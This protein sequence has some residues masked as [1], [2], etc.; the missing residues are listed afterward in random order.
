[1][2]TRAAGRPEES[3]VAKR[4]LFNLSGRISRKAEPERALPDSGAERIRGHQNTE[5]RTAGG[6]ADGPRLKKIVPH[7]RTT[8]ANNLHDQ[9]KSGGYRFARYGSRHVLYYDRPHAVEQPHRYT[10]THMYVDWHDRIC[11]RI[12]WPRYH[13]AVGYHWGPS[14]T[15]RYVYPYYLRKY[16]FVSIGGYWPIEYG[17]IRYYWY[18]YH[19][20]YWCGYYPVAQQVQGDTYNYYTYNYYYDDDG[21]VVSEPSPAIGGIEP[22]KYATFA[23]AR[24]EVVQQAVEPS[25]PTAA[26]HYFEE[27]VKAFEAGDYNTAAASF[28]RAMEYAPDDMVLPFA[29]AQALLAGERYTEAA[30]VLRAA[31]QKISPEKEGV[32]Y[33]RGLYA[34]DD[35]LAQQIDLLAKKAELY[36]YD[37]D[38]Q[39]LWGYQLLGIGEVDEALEPLSR[40]MQDL[41][42]ASAA[43]VL[44][45]LAEK[46]RAANGNAETVV[47]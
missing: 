14:W 10:H 47:P 35:V 11:H 21:A 36:S 7:D 3:S 27:A 12:I 6:T 43:K 31:L 25:Q 9:D 19:P 41:Q 8:I 42:N 16:V 26:D 44:L 29:Y 13:F 1:M 18:G 39:L 45:D 22:V 30:E 40:A 17:Y 46:I 24:Q 15:L 34:D 38:L 5:P 32:F 23:D 2:G 33:P 20:Y 37:A 4:G 28:A